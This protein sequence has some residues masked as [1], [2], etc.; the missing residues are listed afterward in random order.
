MTYIV[1]FSHLKFEKDGGS[2]VVTSARNGGFEETYS[3]PS[4]WSVNDD[5]L[6]EKLYRNYFNRARSTYRE[7]FE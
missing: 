6:R 7:T 3:W 1:R 2:I 4:D 5:D